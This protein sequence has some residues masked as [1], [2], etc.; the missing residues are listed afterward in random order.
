MGITIYS[1]NISNDLGYGGFYHLRKTIASLCPTE[2]KEHYMLLTDHY[3]DIQL[4]D[5]GFKKYDAKTEKIYQLYRKD[6]GKVI[7][8]L[9]TPDTDC[10][11]T[12][13]TAKQLMKVIADYDNDIIYGYSGRGD[14]AMKFKDFKDILKDAV[15][16]KSSWGWR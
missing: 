7:D 2:L 14:S 9:W 15:D 6:Y 4:E 12:Y 11:L 16:T 1:K 5:P 8:F 3:F 10:T 13:G